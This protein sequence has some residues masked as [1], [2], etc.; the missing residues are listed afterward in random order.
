M[1]AEDGIYVESVSLVKQVESSKNG[2][3]SPADYIKSVGGEFS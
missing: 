2:M 3:F 1:K